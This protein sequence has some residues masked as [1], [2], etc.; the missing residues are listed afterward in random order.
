MTLLFSIAGYALDLSSSAKLKRL[1]LRLTGLSPSAKEYKAINQL[2]SHEA[3]AGYLEAKANEYIQSEYFT[4]RVAH[5]FFDGS[6]RSNPPLASS[7]DTPFRTRIYNQ[8]FHHAIYEQIRLDSRFNAIYGKN[9]IK[10]IVDLDDLL[11]GLSYINT[12]LQK[13]TNYVDTAREIDLEVFQQYFGFGNLNQVITEKTL[14]N[15]NKILLEAGIDPVSSR[16]LALGVA[17]L[18]KAGRIKEAKLISVEIKKVKKALSVRMDVSGPLKGRLSLTPGSFIFEWLQSDQSIINE[19]YSLYKMQA[20]S[21]DPIDQKQYYDEMLKS[22]LAFSDNYEDQASD[23]FA[24]TYFSDESFKNTFDQTIYS[25][26]AALYRDLL[27]DDMEI[28]TDPKD[29]L[30]SNLTNSLKFDIES[31]KVES[32]PITKNFN[33][34]SKK[35]CSSCHSKLDPVQEIFNDSVSKKTKVPFFNNLDRMMFVEFLPGDNLVEK[36]MSTDA[37]K[38]CQTSKLWTWFVGDD[39]SIPPEVQEKLVDVFQKTDGNIKELTKTITSTDLFYRGADMDRILTFNDVKPIF[40]R[41]Y[42]CHVSEEAMVTS[43]DKYPFRDWMGSKTNQVLDNIAKEIDLEN[44]GSNRKMPIGY[45]LTKAELRSISQW[46]LQGARSED[47]KIHIEQN[48]F[49][50]RS[51]LKANDK[52]QKLDYQIGFGFYR[53]LDFMQFTYSLDA[54]LAR[55]NA[56]KYEKAIRSIGPFE[57]DVFRR[58]SYC[59]HSWNINSESIYA[60]LNPIDRTSS[61]AQN[62]KIDE[63]FYGVI[64]RCILNQ[65]RFY[66]TLFYYLHSKYALRLEALGLNSFQMFSQELAADNPLVFSQ[67]LSILVDAII[68]EQV[69]SE[70]EKAQLVSNIIQ[71]YRSLEQLEPKLRSLDMKLK[72]MVIKII[73]HPRFM[74]Y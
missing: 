29:N 53:P 45:E 28:Q 12:D 52:L 73:E 50:K 49:A 47:G 40:K 14:N 19:L 70:K 16:E 2:S 25:E 37:Y 20:S 7:S 55:E 69:V 57:W 8:N 34:H 6:R 67:I 74:R 10:H 63:S 58:G 71:R 62:T 33:L 61:K 66:E 22:L 21:S 3:V 41:C 42:N 24:G 39:V 5:F 36:L 4:A 65:D 35:E 48:S 32:I 1:K 60:L 11:T 46:L 27:C 15:L 59:E 38:R 17:K 44:L 68:G 18:M 23:S 72:F 64:S 9:V 26:A 13:L 43:F 56:N 30:Q 31:E 51:A 54:I